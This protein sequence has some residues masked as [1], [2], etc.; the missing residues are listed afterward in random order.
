MRRVVINGQ[1]WLVGLKWDLIDKRT[2]AELIAEADGAVDTY[3]RMVMLGTQYGLARTGGKPLWKKTSS[4][5]AALVQNGE[6]SE[7]S[8]F[9]LSDADTSQPFFWV[10]AVQR[11]IIS[12]RSDRCFD[13]EAEAENMVDSLRDTLG[14]ETVRRFSPDEG[15]SYLAGILGKLPRAAVRAARLTPLHQLTREGF[16][17]VAASILLLI[18][19]GWGLS[20]FF[21]YRDRLDRIERSRVSQERKA[22][23][24]REV[25][26]YPE[27]HFPRQWMTAPNPEDVILQCVPAM[28]RQPLAANG[29]KLSALSCRENG[30]TATWEQT[31]FSEYEYLPFDAA[32]DAK[33]PRLAVS[34]APVPGTFPKTNRSVN[35][36]L[37]EEEVSLSLYAFTQR[38]G[39]KTRLSF[40]KRAV[41][42]VEKEE[43]ACP[44]TTSTW[45]LSGLPAY[46]IVD[47]QNLARALNIPGLL[48][49][50][51]SYADSSWKLKGELYA[52]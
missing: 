1:S 49:K 21:E 47:Y 10:I 20:S 36:L 18:G 52:K 50:E 42:K 30:M 28:L 34:H 44:W 29:W 11:D 43:V 2:R 35:G 33:N 8:V 13:S 16:I 15:T 38:F 45:E 22:A 37:S 31:D 32:L 3:D 48:I 6:A 26:T 9:S 46:L 17:K 5:A 19:V 40:G 4:L 14:I 23:R 51:I 39:L 12:A 7:I 27:R 24:I 25:R 41:K